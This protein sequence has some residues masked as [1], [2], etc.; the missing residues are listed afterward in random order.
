VLREPNPASSNGGTEAVNGVIEVRGRIARGCR[1]VAT[2]SGSAWLSLPANPVE[3]QLERRL[4]PKYK[5][6]A[7]I[8]WHTPL[9]SWIRMPPTGDRQ[10][11]FRWCS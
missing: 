1:N 8:K 9:A 2:I 6:T 7:K 10:V 5:R 4:T 11:S 3:R